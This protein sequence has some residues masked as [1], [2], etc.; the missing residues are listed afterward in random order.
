MIFLQ[1]LLNPIKGLIAFNKLP[2]WLQKA[3][4]PRQ[5][6]MSKA[7]KPKTEDSDEELKSLK[8]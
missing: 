8:E 2:K 6:A 4:E 7:L 5:V 1:N 3:D